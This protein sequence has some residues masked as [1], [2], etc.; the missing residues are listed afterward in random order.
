MGGGLGG[1]FNGNLG[2]AGATQAGPLI[3]LI[4]Q[5]VAPGEWFMTPAQQAFFQMQGQ[6]GGFNFQAGGGFNFGNFNFGGQFNFQPGGFNFQPGGM[7]FQPGGMGFAPGGMGIQGG[8]FQPGFN[9]AGFQAQGF[10]PA[11]TPGFVDPRQMNTI[12]FFAPALALIVRAP[13]KI[14]Y[15][16]D[17]GIF[18]RETKKKKEGVGAIPGLGLND[19]DKGGAQFAGNND[20][21]NKG[22]VAGVKDEDLDPKKIWEEGLVKSGGDPGLI[23]ATADFLFENQKYEHVAELL[24]AN[25]RLGLVVRPWVYEALAIAMEASGQGS[26]E[27]IQRLRLSGLSLDPNDAGSYLEAAHVMAQHK[28]WNRAIAFCRQAA[29]IV[30]G[31]PRPYEDALVYAAKGKDSDAMTWAAEKLL[32]QDWSVDNERLHNLAHL[33]VDALMQVLER[34]G[35]KDAAQQL[36][37]VLNHQQVRDLIVRL[38]WEPGTSG[39]ADLEL[40]VKEPNGTVCSSQTRQTP[41]GGLLIGNNLKHLTQASY[42]AAQAFAGEYQITVQP[43]WGRPLGGKARLEIITHQGTPK[44]RRQFLSITV[45]KEYTRTFRLEEGNRTAVATVTPIAP[46]EPASAKEESSVNILAKLRD[47]VD[48]YQSGSSYHGI[49]GGVATS[50]ASQPL[51]TPTVLPG[52]RANGEQLIYQ[53]AVSSNGTSPVNLTANATISTEGDSQNLRLQLSPNLNELSQGSLQINLPLI[54]GGS[55]N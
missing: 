53:A 51:Q 32:A 12:Q 19:N 20:P 27:E 50:M 48:P 11:T 8:G 4:M 41:G 55:A 17:G 30:P 25:L 3:N 37:G 43:L 7:Q 29:L 15:K 16:A 1:G 38:S 10:N 23:I 36:K 42:I 52:R 18:G 34:D 26:P 6:F 31:H 28:D 54:P 47:I 45:G 21:K 14:H 40:Q 9:A 22:G 24:K 44:E 46:S 39:P 33:K 49:R 2:F 13:S 35:K 5:V